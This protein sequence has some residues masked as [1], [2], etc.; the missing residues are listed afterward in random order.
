M[1]FEPLLYFSLTPNMF[2][3][4]VQNHRRKDFR[5]AKMKLKDGSL[6]AQTPIR[7]KLVAPTN[8][9]RFGLEHFDYV[10]IYTLFYITMYSIVFEVVDKLVLPEGCCFY[11]QKHCKLIIRI[12]AGAEA[13]QSNQ[14]TS[15]EKL[16]SDCE[17][18]TNSAVL[19]PQPCCCQAC[20]N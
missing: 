10:H 18:K 3:D 15:L 13:H 16:T 9:P 6:I 11:L 8:Y 14:C 17:T 2:V 7:R 20:L 19:I 5:Y 1:H 4:Y 12:M